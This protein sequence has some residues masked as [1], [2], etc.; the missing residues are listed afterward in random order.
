[1]V[2][3]NDRERITQSREELHLII[4][5]ESLK[6]AVILIWAN[7]QDL[8]NALSVEEVQDALCMTQIIE[9]SPEFLR[10]LAYDTL[11]KMLPDD[12]IATL[13]SYIPSK[14]CRS[15]HNKWANYWNVINDTMANELFTGEYIDKW[16][17]TSTK[18]H[19]GEIIIE[20]A[21]PYQSKIGSQIVKIMPCSI[22]TGDGLYEG[23]DW[24][25]DQLNKSSKKKS[26]SIL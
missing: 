9:Q 13:S 21:G 12:V 1:M 26:C 6:D 22:I 15:Y 10:S 14:E 11:L 24:L 17:F 16:H 3:S 18:A 7:K 8:P 19:I 5:D 25:S 4:S 20:Y 2:D 23:L